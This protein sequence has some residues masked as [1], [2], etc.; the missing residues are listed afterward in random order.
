Y[1]GEK[2]RPGR[3][4]ILDKITRLVF[5]IG[6]RPSA[7]LLIENVRVERDESTARV[8]FAGLHAFDLGPSSGP[9]MEG[10]TPI[11][12]ATLY[13]PGRGYGLKNARIWRAVDA[14]QPDPLYQD[15][16]CIEAGGL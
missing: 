1:V 13:S 12:P 8:G 5:S 10:F 2:S 11:T 15:F 7:P 4:L 3:T 14:L 16:L 9:V 6:E